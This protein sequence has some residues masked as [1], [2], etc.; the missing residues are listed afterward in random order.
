MTI[1]INGK[2]EAYD[3]TPGSFATV[4]RH[5]QNGDVIDVRLP[6]RL[7]T[8]PLPGDPRTVALFYGP[9]LLAGDLGSEGLT[10]TTRY[11]M[12]APEIAKLPP[13]TIPGLVLSDGDVV[14]RIRAVADRP[15]T[16]RTEGL[17]QP[18][19]VTLLPFFRVNDTRY[20]VYWRLFSPAEWTAHMTALDAVAS[21]PARSRTPHRRRRQYRQRQ[22]RARSRRRRTDRSETAVVRGPFGSRIE[23][24]AVQLPIEAAARRCRSVAVTYRG[25]SNQSRVFDLLVD[26]EVVARETLPV[27]PTELVDIERPVP[28]ALTHGKSTIRIGFRPAADATTGAVF[29]VRTL[30]SR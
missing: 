2:G 8:E 16:F 5:W 23:N 28:A 24:G 15:L 18:H 7:R 30:T 10:A 21:A 1:A 4:V 22:Q 20:T 3:G 13:V 27:K 11:G 14:S 12:T 19:D 9:V 17:A 26:G 29:E 6:M 25:A